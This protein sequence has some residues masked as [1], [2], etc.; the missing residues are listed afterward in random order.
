MTIEPEYIDMLQA[1][2]LILKNQ[3]D[4]IKKLTIKSCTLDLTKGHLNQCEAALES[5]DELNDTLNARI[6][7]LEK[8]L[9]SL[10]LLPFE[11]HK[12]ECAESVAGIALRKLGNEK[13]W[14]EIARLNSLVFPDVSA[15][16]YYPVG[17]ILLLPNLKA[18]KDKS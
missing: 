4:E 13:L 8:E 18:L 5:R 16:D 1:K 11:T 12:T 7:E 17:T 3:L 6:A 9:D 14:V 15:N 2:D 10:K